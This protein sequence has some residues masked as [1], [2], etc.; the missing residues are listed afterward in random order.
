MHWLYPRPTAL[1]SGSHLQFEGRCF[2]FRAG[3]CRPCSEVN[4]GA[5]SPVYCMARRRNFRM[6]LAAVLMA[7]RSPH[8][9][10]SFSG[11][12]G[13]PLDHLAFAQK[14]QNYLLPFPTKS[15]GSSC[16]PTVSRSVI[17]HSDKTCRTGPFRSLQKRHA[18]VVDQPCRARSARR[19][20]CFAFA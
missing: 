10:I 7:T 6:I 4:A 1:S 19:S 15:T 16:G 17:R 20:V 11:V 8:Q 3:G 18:V 5:W 13:H 12:S 9:R 14:M 2:T